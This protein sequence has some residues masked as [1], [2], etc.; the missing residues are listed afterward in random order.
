MLIDQGKFHDTPIPPQKAPALPPPGENQ[1]PSAVA[2]SKEAITP[3][4]ATLA[5]LQPRRSL[6]GIS[7]LPWLVWGQET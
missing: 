1:K 3:E 4:K 5:R 2:Y 7:L 6:R